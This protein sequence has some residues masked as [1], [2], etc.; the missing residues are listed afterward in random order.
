MT[1]N[2]DLYLLGSGVLSFLDVT[3]YTQKILR[4]CKTVFFLHDMPTL[5]RFLKEITPNPV[6]RII[7]HLLRLRPGQAAAADAAAPRS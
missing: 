1:P 3:L 2:A 7:G 4:Q 6:N 5:G